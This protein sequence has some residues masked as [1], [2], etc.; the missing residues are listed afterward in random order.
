MGTRTTGY[1]NSRLLLFRAVMDKQ[2]AEY[3]QKS[4]MV[5]RAARLHARAHLLAPPAAPGCIT[6]CAFYCLLTPTWQRD[7]HRTPSAM[8]Q[9]RWGACSLSVCK[10][11]ECGA[12][13]CGP[14]LSGIPARAA[15]LDWRASALSAALSRSG[16]WRGR[17]S[18]AR[19]WRGA[20]WGTP[21][22]TWSSTRP[23]TCGC[24]RATPGASGQRRP[25]PSCRERACSADA[26]SSACSGVS[27]VCSQR[28]IQQ[29]QAVGF[30]GAECQA[31]RA[32]RAA[33]PPVA[34]EAA[35][36][37]VSANGVF[38]AGARPCPADRG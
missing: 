11:L 16:A 2:L 4:I 5:V 32:H 35:A 25:R 6:G 1:Q 19:G 34:F 37:L 9:S 14:P 33:G 29:S 7:S 22:A 31:G 28:A 20:C 26:C 38:C 17:R 27:D 13:C 15:A 3:I 12:A 30:D 24:A 23:G 18:R 8:A 21:R 10:L 36:R